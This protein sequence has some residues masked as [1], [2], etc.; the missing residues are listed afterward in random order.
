MTDVATAPVR[1]PSARFTIGVSLKMYFSHAKTL[2][3][4]TEVAE[5]AR[6][7]PA[8]RQGVVE[9][10]V[11][12]TF[13]SLVPVQEAL[14]GTPV[15][16]GAQD[17]ATDDAG[18][19]TG[20]VSGAELAEIGCTLA[21][22][23]HAERRALFHEDDA[24]VAAKTAAALRHG[25][26]PL[27]C[28]GEADETS[29]ALAAL[30]VT[31]QLDLALAA[32][33]EAGLAG[34]LLVAYEPLWA[35]GAPVPASAGHITAV[36][37]AVEEH[38]AGLPDRAGSRVIYGGSAGP[39]LLTGLGGQ[40]R[41]LFLGRFAHDPSA[42]ERILDEALALALDETLADDDD[43]ADATATADTAAPRDR[44]TS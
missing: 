30:E 31:Q 17:L 28:V 10:F 19:F 6:R 12:P 5:I 38:L 35:I 37:A 8:L 36:V 32:A 44:V 21:E 1:P 29:P 33:D 43:S 13:P 15:R 11:V 14:A 27:L 20:E 2:A 9:L 39:G 25:I 18:A 16:L 34:A 26:T 22:I 3:W 40:V 4:S 7:H 24:V 23:G 42:V 41:G